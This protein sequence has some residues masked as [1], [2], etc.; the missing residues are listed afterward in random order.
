MK[1]VL[2]SPIPCKGQG[3]PQDHTVG[4]PDL[5]E[6]YSLLPSKCDTNLA[7]SILTQPWVLTKATYS[8]SA[9]LAEPKLT[10]VSLHMSC[11]LPGILAFFPTSYQNPTCSQLPSQEY[12]TPT[13]DT[14][15]PIW[16]LSQGTL[17]KSRF[18]QIHMPCSSYPPDYKLL[19]G[20][21]PGL[22]HPG[23]P[24]MVSGSESGV[25]H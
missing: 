15:P 20:Q 7:S 1:I 11:L 17:G 5:N 10:A 22:E 23:M 25:Y 21:G 3:H 16:L 9:N 8:L 19:G 2:T 18:S 24:S 12:I 6:F 4:T 13:D 14:T